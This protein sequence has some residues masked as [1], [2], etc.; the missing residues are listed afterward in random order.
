[1]KNIF[2]KYLAV[3]FLLLSVTACEDFL[4]EEVQGILP[5]EEYYQTEEDA[6]MAVIGIYDMMSAHYNGVWS[7]LYFVKTMP[8]DES[9]AGGSNDGDQ[10]GYQDLD[11]F[12]IDSQND[13]VG[14]TWSTIYQAILRA[15]NVVNNTE[16]ESELQKRSIAEAK[17]LRSMNYFDLVRLWGDVPLVLTNINPDDFTSIGRAPSSDVYAQIEKDLLEAIPELPLKSQYVAQDKFRVSK[18]TA[19]ALLGKVYLYQQNWDG[20]V[21]QFEN[22]ITSGEYALENSVADVFSKHGEFGQESLFELSYTNGENY[23][24]GNFPWGE[25]PESNIHIQLMGPRS[26]FY[27]MAPGDSLIGGWGFNVGTE[28]MYQAFVDAGDVNRR[29]VS[30]MSVEELENAGGNWSVESTWD[31]EGY[32]QRKYGTFQSHTDEPI[33]EL[34]YGTNW[35]MIRYAD[36]LL[37]AAEAHY[38]NGN[39]PQALTYLNQVRQRPGTNLPEVSATG[40]ALFDAIVLE[41]QLELAFEGHRYMDLVRWG[42]AE[43]ELGPLGFTSGKNEVLPIPINE[44]RTAGLEQNPQY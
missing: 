4:D 32:W 38:R 31:F 3:A 40:A 22:V 34:N 21:T 2:I 16:P 11:D 5:D 24:W 36:V 18:G 9:N 1:M 15:N 37:M 10:K 8:S 23:D 14:A 33:L 7:S 13:K 17:A 30:M 25:K 12:N 39:E 42:L 19:Q 29:M 35:R 41:R 28:K 6:M 20:A 44:I 26:D 27:T 43:Q